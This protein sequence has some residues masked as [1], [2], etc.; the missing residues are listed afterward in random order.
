MKLLLS[1]ALLIAAGQSLASSNWI[2][3]PDLPGLGRHRATA[4]SIGTKGYVGLG[5]FNGTGTET[6]FSDW[7]EYDPASCTWTQKADYI[8]N[9]GNGE[10]GAQAMGLETIG[11]VGI[12]ELDKYSFYR[13]EPQTNSWTQV[14]SVASGTL[15]Q[16]TDE[17]VIGHKGYFLNL[18]NGR[19][20]EYDADTDQWTQK[21]V[22]PFS[23]YFSYTG[24][25]ING[26][27]Y[28][29]AVDQLWEYDPAT[30]Q[31]TLKGNFPGYAKYSSIDFV[32]NDKAYIICGYNST[33]SD[34]TSE[35]WEYDPS[36]NTWSLHGQFP[37][38]SRRYSSGFNIGNRCYLV[39]GTNGTNF[40]DFWEFDSVAK[41][42]EI[43]AEINCNVYP[44]PATE[45]V[46]IESTELNEFT[47]K[48]MNS[49]GQEMTEI[50]TANGSVRLNRETMQSGIYFC[51]IFSEHKLIRTEKIVFE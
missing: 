1:I 6:Y 9:G 23:P 5:H 18:Y 46:L 12:G 7:W 31:W 43:T 25:S 19:I 8:G 41:T 17:M 29:K 10:L 16:D 51:Q 27:G 40:K 20:W 34:L 45:F 50:T 44:N 49:A 36:S 38:S 32:Q 21:N 13:Y 26:K 47:V 11:F 22:A 48:V 3:R 39:T 4:I 2:Q 15:F 24:F 42:T 14:S 35:V 33:Y 37:G 28:T 30:D